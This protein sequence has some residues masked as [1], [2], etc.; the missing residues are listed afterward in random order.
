MVGFVLRAVIAAFG[1]WLAT[2]WVDGF[3][4]DE[5]LTLLIAAAALGIGG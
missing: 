3:T 5:P 4:I 2:R 1:L